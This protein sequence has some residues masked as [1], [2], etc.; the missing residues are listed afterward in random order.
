MTV[1]IPWNDVLCFF[2][3]VSSIFNDDTRKCTTKYESLLVPQPDKDNGNV[4]TSEWTQPNHVGSNKLWTSCWRNLNPVW[5]LVTR[6][7]PFVIMALVLAWDIQVHG[8]T[9]FLYY[10]KWTFAL[11]VFYFTLG[12]ITSA[13]GCWENSRKPVNQNNGINSSVKMSMAE[14]SR[15]KTT[16]H[17][18]ANKVR[19]TVKVQ[20]YHEQDIMKE[21][22]EFLG[23]LMQTVYQ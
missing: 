9:V 23:Y 10:T 22:A 3:V 16:I 15:S 14:S 1:V 21:I 19:A 20:S 4:I 13:Q 18:S 7:L 11:V 2:I 17:F 5:L 8:K 6:F 12:T